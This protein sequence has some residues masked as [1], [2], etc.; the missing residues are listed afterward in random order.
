METNIASAHHLRAR[1]SPQSLYMSMTTSVDVNQPLPQLIRSLSEHFQKAGFPS[2]LAEAEWLLAGILQTRRSELYVER[3]RVLT[4]EQQEI[5]KQ[6]YCRRL[7]REPLQY[8]LQ[9]CEFFGIEFKVNSAVLIPR[10]ETELLV[11]KVIAL[12]QTFNAVR[13]A[14]LG[15]GSGCLAVSLAKHLPAAKLLAIDISAEA[16]KVAEENAQANGV[17]QKITFRQ[18]DMCASINAIHSD[19][20]DIV[21]SNPP[22]IL[23]AERETLQPEIRDFEPEAAL[24]V[25][26]DGLKFY[27]CILAFCQRHLKPSGWVACEMASQRSAAIE[28][29]F[30]ES[31]FAS[32]EIMPDYAGL[33]RHLTAQKS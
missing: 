12:A 8:I 27:R 15:A 20:F 11:E 4:V 14:D 6:Y 24:F 32:V 33:Y 17:A 23:P 26:G 2:A 25:E 13:I 10:P 18:A 7:Q 21:V 29:L 28:K 22:Y 1:Q 19:Q 5:L 30:R 9:S 31:N 3:N 16:L